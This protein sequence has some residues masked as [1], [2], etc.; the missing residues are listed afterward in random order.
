MY[1]ALSLALIVLFA[2]LVTSVTSVH[3]TEMFWQIWT[4]YAPSYAIRQLRSKRNEMIKVRQERSNTSSQDEF[5]KWARLDRE[6]QRLKKEYDAMN[7]EVAATRQKVMLFVRVT[8]WILSTG[9]LWV[10][11]WLYRKSPVVWLPY[12]SLPHRVEW[13]IA[14]PSAPLG[15]ISVVTWV[16]SLNTAVSTLTNLSK[17]WS[18]RKKAHVS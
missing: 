5:A 7:S 13:F 3:M 11:Q 15:S 18:L 17:R 6:H 12:N 9:L 2:R 14:L 4:S 1:L 8:K 10:V 16:L